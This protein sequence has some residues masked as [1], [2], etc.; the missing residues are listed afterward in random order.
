MRQWR[1]GRSGDVRHNNPT[2]SD[3]PAGEDPIDRAV[4]RV[5][6]NDLQTKLFAG[7]LERF[8]GPPDKC[9]EVR[10]K[11]RLLVTAGRARGSR[12]EPVGRGESR[13]QHKS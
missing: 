4:E 7:I 11:Q 5:A 1:Y 8:L 9:Q 2:L 3:C 13:K 6:A 10:E 12:S